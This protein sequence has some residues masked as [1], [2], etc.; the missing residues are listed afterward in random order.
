M[1]LSTRTR[2][3]ARALVEIARHRGNPVAVKV[4][5]ESQKISV[6]YLE[7]LMK[8]LKKHDLVH[9]F[10]GVD[11][12]YVLGRDA[13][14]IT[15]LDIYTAVEG[16]VEFVECVNDPDSCSIYSTCPTNCVW[17]GLSRVV[18]E[19]L[20]SYTVHALLNNSSKE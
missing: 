1:K 10:R 4:I 2:Y 9:S 13:R 20:S 19:Y 15:M 17:T 5:S 12:G 18:R 8:N 16:E 11:G 6:K 14:Q 3:A 7:N